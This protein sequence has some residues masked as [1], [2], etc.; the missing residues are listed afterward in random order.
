[1]NYFIYEKFIKNIGC[2]DGRL[3]KIPQKN[4]EFGYGSTRESNVSLNSDQDDFELKD[5]S[6]ISVEL[7]NFL[8]NEDSGVI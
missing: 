6:E 1:M 4:Y 7:D 8:Q 2:K 5:I 3:E